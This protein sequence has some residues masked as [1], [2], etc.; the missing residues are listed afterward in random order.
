MLLFPKNIIKYFIFIPI[1]ILFKI[2]FLYF[3]SYFWYFCT[4][5]LPRI[6]YNRF[7]TYQMLLFGVNRG[8]GRGV[9]EANPR[10]I[11][12]FFIF[13]IILLLL[14]ILLLKYIIK[15]NIILYLVIVS[16]KYYKNDIFFYKIFYFYIFFLIFS[17]FFFLL[18]V[19]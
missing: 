17:I 13:V 5:H 6:L 12:T 19:L 1:L 3:S 7:I 10:D 16:E 8:S 9:S 2:C 11:I 4:F 14:L 18:L 15:H